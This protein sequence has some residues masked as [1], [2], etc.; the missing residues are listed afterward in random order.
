MITIFVV[1]FSA[2][3]INYSP[4]NIVAVAVAILFSTF[5]YI[6]L[7]T[8]LGLFA[9]SV[10]EASVIVLPVII[11]FSFGS[12]IAAL[13]EKYPILKMA[14]YLPNVQ[15]IELA[16]KVEV[17]LGFADVIGNLGVILG[18]AIFVIALTII[19][20]RKRMVD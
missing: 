12:F 19:V 16:S 9:K 2:L 14:N 10:M 8:L 5:F 11:V 1:F 20:Y 18:W 7:G 13:A 17:G 6:G 3:L 15:L 4:Q